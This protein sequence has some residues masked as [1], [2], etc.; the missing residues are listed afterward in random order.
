MIRLVAFEDFSIDRDSELWAMDVAE[1]QKSYVA[2]IQIILGRAYVFRE[3]RPRIFWIFDGD[4]AV[5]MALYYDDPEKEA[6]DFSQIFIDHRHQ[7]KGCGSAAVRLVLDEMKKDGKY[8]KV[9]MCY[10]EGNEESRKLFGK[11]GFVEVSHP[12]DEIFMEA[13]L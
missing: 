8:S 10:V 3:L 12:W 5:G 2:S 7:Q 6:Y 4:T 9:T 13:E 1:E 11:F